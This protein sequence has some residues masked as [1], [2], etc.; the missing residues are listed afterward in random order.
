MLIAELLVTDLR[1]L[2]VLW[3]KKVKILKIIQKKNLHA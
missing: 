1:I 2:N 3:Q